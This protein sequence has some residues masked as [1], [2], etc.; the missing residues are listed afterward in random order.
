M[1]TRQRIVAAA[2]DLFAT[3][4]YQATTLAAIARRAGVS[5]E[6]VKAAASKAELLIA[7]FEV[8]FAGAESA[9]S[10]TDTE[11]AAAVLDL[12]DD[13]FLDTV[14]RQIALANA[15]GYALWTVL[16]G[17]AASDPV[18]EAALQGMLER[19]AADYLRL[20]DELIARRL[21]PPT[22]ER[23]ERA[24]AVSFLLSP[25]GYQQ[26]VAQSG[27]T[28]EDYLTWVGQAVRAEMS[29]SAR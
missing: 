20:V 1:Q 15:R 6:T 19:R 5:A 14:I 2:A 26:L 13:V 4:G 3:Q 8:T 29:R 22:S 28:Y 23:R 7:A 16:L 17:A 21:A 10:L 27:R 9:R 24:A 18:V 12:P 11:V 25:E